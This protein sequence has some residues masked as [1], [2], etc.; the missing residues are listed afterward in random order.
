VCAHNRSKVSIAAWEKCGRAHGRG[1][2]H[3]RAIPVA[4][5]PGAVARCVQDVLTASRAARS[6][7]VIDTKCTMEAG[8]TVDHDNIYVQD[9]RQ[10]E[11]GRCPG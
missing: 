5:V 4:G 11:H 3:G 2:R 1:E 10:A 6:Q 8:C 7:P 9:A